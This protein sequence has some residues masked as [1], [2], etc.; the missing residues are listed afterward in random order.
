[1]QLTAVAVQ[2]PILLSSVTTAVKL[3][4][5]LVAILN[6]SG[7]FVLEMKSS[8]EEYVEY[9]SVLGEEMRS[10]IFQNSIIVL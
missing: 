3:Y 7:S 6:Q 4:G 1:M 10:I 5:L 8:Q 9:L 2:R